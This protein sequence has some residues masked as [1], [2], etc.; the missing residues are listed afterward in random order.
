VG[1]LYLESLSILWVNPHGQR[2]SD[3]ELC[4]QQVDLEMTVSVVTRL[5]LHVLG[6]LILWANLF[7]IVWVLEGKRKH[8]LLLQVRLMNTGK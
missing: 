3:C 4:A 5:G 7:I 6:Y 8:A 2:L 1:E